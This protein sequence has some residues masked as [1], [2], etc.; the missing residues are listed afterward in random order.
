MATRKIG[1]LLFP[2]VEELDF[3]GPWEVLAFWTRTAPEDGWEAL[4]F[5]RDGVEVQCAKGL[6]VIPDHS[7]ATVPDLD[8]LVFPGGMG[9]RPLIHDEPML[10][11]LRDQR[12]RIP[13]ITSV[14]TG[15][16]VL[17]AAGLLTDRPAT[18]HWLSL[19]VLADLDPTIE[20]RPDAR[21]VDAGDIIT[22][23]GV[24]AGTDMALHLLQR[25]AGD[26][27]AQWVR[28][29]IQYDPEPPAGTDWPAGKTWEL[30][31][32]DPRK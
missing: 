27:R 22:S 17:A 26:E 5:S 30:G 21:Y 20:V 14:C 15:A 16:L 11:W 7:F 12:P 24:S 10:T 18:T 13:L 25:L 6:R 28:R 29:G 3:A 23:A 32:V 19:D 9:T 4:T 31:S 1:I 2:G 8:V